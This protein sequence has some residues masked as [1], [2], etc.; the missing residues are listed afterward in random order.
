MDIKTKKTVFPARPAYWFLTL[1]LAGLATLLVCSPAAADSPVQDVPVPI[2]RWMVLNPETNKLYLDSYAGG[3]FLT[4]LN[5]ATYVTK[6]LAYPAYTWYVDAAADPLHNRIYILPGSYLSDDPILVVNGAT[7]AWTTSLPVPTGTSRRENKALAVDAQGRQVYFA[8][9]TSSSHVLVHQ[10]DAVTG[11]TVGSMDVTTGDVVDLAYNPTNG[12][13]YLLTA[14]FVSGSWDHNTVWVLDMAGDDVLLDEDIDV[15]YA[16]IVANEATGDVYVGT[17][18]LDGDRLVILTR[19]LPAQARVVNSYTNKVYCFDN[20]GTLYE[21][22]GA[23]LTSTALR[24]FANIDPTY[25]GDAMAINPALNKLYLFSDQYASSYMYDPTRDLLQTLSDGMTR[26]AAV[27]PHNHRLYLAPSRA[28]VSIYGGAPTL[29]VSP[30]ALTFVAVQDGDDPPTQGFIVTMNSNDR[31]NLR[32]TVTSDAAWL[33]AN[34]TGRFLE[35]YPVSTTLEAQV[36]VRVDI[37]G[38]DIGDHTGHLT[39][40]SEGA[41]SSPRT[42]T[43]NLIVGDGEDPLMRVDAGNPVRFEVMEGDPAPAPHGMNVRN[44]G[45]VSLTYTVVEDIPWLDVVGNASG[46]VSANV[47]HPITL[48]LNSTYAALEPGTYSAP[49]TITSDSLGS[50]QSVNVE[51]LIYPRARLALSTRALP[52]NAF[53]ETGDPAMQYLFVN[54]GGGGVVDWTATPS[55]AWLRTSGALSGRAPGAFQVGADITAL[56]L[57]M[58]DGQIT[59]AAGAGVEDSPQTVDVTLKVDTARRMALSKLRLDDFAFVEGTTPAAQSFRIYNAGEGGAFDWEA[60]TDVAWLTLNAT[61]GTADES[62]TTVQVSV[63]PAQLSVGEHQATITVRGDRVKGA[64]QTVRVTAFV[65]SAS[66]P[67]CLPDAHVDVVKTSLAKITVDIV[68]VDAYHGA[69]CDVTA[70]VDLHFYGM[71]RFYR[72]YQVQGSISDANALLLP[73]ADTLDLT[74]AKVG[75]TLSAIEIGNDALT[76]QGQWDFGELLGQT[77]SAGQVTLG[78]NGLRFDGSATF[79][80]NQSWSFEGFSFSADQ[81]TVHAAQSFNELTLEVDGELTIKIFGSRDV[82]I[83]VTLVISRYGKVR[84]KGSLGEVPLPNFNFT[85]AGFTVQTKDARFLDG[86]VEIA[87]AEIKSPAN[88]GGLGT[89]IYN[90][91]I[92]GNGKVSV[93]GGKLKLPALKAGGLNLMSLEGALRQ[94]TR[95][96]GTNGLLQP[97]ADGYEITAGGEFGVPGMGS[98]G[99]CSINVEVTVYMNTMGATVLELAPL[100]TPIPAAVNTVD[101][102]ALRQATL[103]VHCL[104][105]V[106]IGNTSF[107]ITGIEGTVTLYD[108][109]ESISIQMW[110]EHSTRIGPESLISTDPKLTLFFSPFAIDFNAKLYLVGVSVSETSVYIDKNHFETSI[111]YDF[112][113]VHGYSSLSAGTYNG[114]AYI[115][116]SGR[117]DIGLSKG[118]IWKKCFVACVKIPPWNINLGSV[119]IDFGTF[120]NGK[121]GVKGTIDVLGLWRGGAFVGFNGTIKFGSLKD[122]QLVGSHMVRQAR[123]AHLQMMQGMA[124]QT[125][126]DPDL[127][128]APNGDTLVRVTIPA[129]SAEGASP[130]RPLAAAAPLFP[131]NV[132]STVSILS[133]DVI[134]ALAQPPGGE[135]AFTIVAPNGT[136]YTPDYL[137]SSMAYEQVVDG[138]GIQ[139]MYAV[140]AALTGDWQVRITGDTDNTDFTLSVIG[141]TPPPATLAAVQATGPTTATVAWIAQVAPISDTTPTASLYAHS[142]PLTRTVTYTNSAGVL[143]TDTAEVFEGILVAEGLTTTNGIDAYMQTFELDMLPSGVYALWIEADDGENPRA[144]RYILSGV[145]SGPAL[146]IT[147]DHSA[148]FPTDWTAALTP[149]LDSIQS[150]DMHVSWRA[151]AHPD[152]LTYILHVATPGTLTPTLQTT[153]V[154]TVSDAV[155]GSVESV[156][157]DNILPGQPY[158][159]TLAAHNQQDGRVA[160]SQ[161]VTFL[162]PQPDFIIMP[163]AA[164]TVAAGHT[165]ALALTLLI[166]DDLPFPLTLAPGYI[167]APD[168]FTLDF[169]PGLITTTGA[170]TASVQIA[171]VPGMYTGTYAMPI[172]AQSGALVRGMVLEVTVVEA[173]YPIY[174][175]LVMR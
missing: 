83:D 14:H 26:W 32:Y 86:K 50:P 74:L 12:M 115:A 93:G 163:T 157:V 108:S 136:E 121:F 40:A 36:Q 99:A 144:R 27:N 89:D 29:N 170:V 69:A 39:V 143:V 113:I 44:L 100:E 33:S 105:G 102:I 5:G 139:S 134:F 84:V 65:A 159:L 172:I 140:R 126:F 13:V 54:N 147:V 107:F 51:L 141:N 120:K 132:I 95:G 160:W 82:K 138:E 71:G 10:I 164:I 98:S 165:T 111:S 152:A 1:L 91:T 35:W 2:S 66:A 162:T 173:H 92:D 16:K 174:L 101:G 158:T 104:P 145:T 131:T 48:A 70:D 56:D 45:A 23:R 125:P 130:T 153:R 90:I 142:G 42:V 63:N 154:F 7:D 30:A 109:I 80:I 6:S 49:L 43:V 4:V 122:Y 149:T 175:P 168:G 150:S 21:V 155:Y 161:P 58:Y 171:A 62:G 118:C 127:S 31:G 15:R 97:A 78:R 75:L 20:G 25:Q 38:L 22:D 148:T 37:N 96:Y 11:A 81:G 87:Q 47:M 166:P 103:G 60:E 3:S 57:G 129:V 17:T 19:S 151:D 88:W 123:A 77:R 112:L 64:V 9:E 53:A 73:I 24:D 72:S 124:P 156:R 68:S 169:T 128:F 116:G 79:P 114:K 146:T 8:E 76:A 135:L 137:L 67:T 106:P 28:Q 34:K 55:G 85:L 59:V 117:T 46:S 167:A 52:F 61:S 119:G 41:N 94:V 133:G 110:I 18:A